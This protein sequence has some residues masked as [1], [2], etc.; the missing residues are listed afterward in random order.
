MEGAV[1]RVILGHIIGN[2]M[3]QKIQALNVRQKNLETMLKKMN[4]E[5]N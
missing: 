3:G 1:C 5:R 2:G 4:R